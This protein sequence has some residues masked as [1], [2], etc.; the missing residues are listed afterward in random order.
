LSKKVA[1]QVK[2]L[3]AMGGPKGDTLKA[4]QGQGQGQGVQAKVESG[5]AVK[6]MDDDLSSVQTGS[7]NRVQTLSMMIRD[8]MVD[9]R[10]F[11]RYISQLQ[12]SN[13]GNLSSNGFVN[14][15]GAAAAAAAAATA[16]TYKPDNDKRSTLNLFKNINSHDSV[17]SGATTD[18][19][20]SR[21]GSSLINTSS[22]VP[23]SQPGGSSFHDG[24][25]ETD[26]SSTM[27]TR[28]DDDAES[29]FDQDDQDDYS[30]INLDVNNCHIID[31]EENAAVE[32]DYTSF[33]YETVVDQGSARHSEPSGMAVRQLMD[34]PLPGYHHLS[35]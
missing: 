8:L 4:D 9:K 19:S 25:A 23:H 34:L 10:K 14:G 22:K 15:G 21:Q 16:M 2:A 1:A 7:S 28:Q 31:A 29:L 17:E 12:R 33:L 32:S 35:D 30:K 26:D 13:Q 18:Y 3:N 27:I 24:D 20:N 11:D 6:A 5:R